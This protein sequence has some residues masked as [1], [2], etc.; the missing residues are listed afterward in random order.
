MKA[1]WFLKMKFVACVCL[2]AV[3]SSVQSAKYRG[4]FFYKLADEA[5]T[6]PMI[7]QIFIGRCSDYQASHEMPHPVDCHDL[8][9]TFSEVFANI[10]PCKVQTAGY[11]KFIQKASVPIPKDSVRYFDYY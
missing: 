7:D 3:I 10:D 2:I 1:T 6:T 11:D 9:K 4:P 8:W 5:G